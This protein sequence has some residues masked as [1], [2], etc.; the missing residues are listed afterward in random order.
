MPAQNTITHTEADE[1]PDERAHDALNA[2]EQRIVKAMESYTERPLFPVTPG[3]VE[4][5]A[6]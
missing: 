1:T 5:T 3:H 6:R 2:Q 4:E